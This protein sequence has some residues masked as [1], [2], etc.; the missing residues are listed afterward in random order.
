[1][2]MVADV[3]LLKREVET[4]KREL[5]LQK[6]INTRRD[7]Q[8]GGERGLSA[9]ITSHN[10]EVKAD[11]RALRRILYTVLMAVVIGSITMAFSAFSLIGGG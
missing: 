7:E 8:I 9:T 10:A 4:L 3:E 5:E 2:T 6:A 1:M 11:I